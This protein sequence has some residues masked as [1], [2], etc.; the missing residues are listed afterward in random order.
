MKVVQIRSKFSKLDIKLLQIGKVFQIGY[1]TRQNW[2]RIAQIGSK[3]VTFD[4]TSKTSS[5]F[6]KNVHIG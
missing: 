6:M 3:S 1:Q 2:I 5:D 4:K